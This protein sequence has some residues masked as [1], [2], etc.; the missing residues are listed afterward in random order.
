[1]PTEK[2]PKHCG[3]PMSRLYIRKGTE[4]RSWIGV[5]Y[6]CNICSKMLNNKEVM[7]KVFITFLAETIP[8]M[9]DRVEEFQSLVIELGSCF[10]RVGYS[11]ETSPRWVFESIV[12]FPSIKS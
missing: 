4:K 6:L 2:L 8:K 11:G 5:G 1:M 3:K 7:K 10:T 12:N 9:K